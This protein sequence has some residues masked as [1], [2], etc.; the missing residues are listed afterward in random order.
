MSSV[1]EWDWTKYKN[2]T[3]DRA[4]TLS[5]ELK[6]QYHNC[7]VMMQKKK[8]LESVVK[9]TENTQLKKYFRTTPYNL[10]KRP[11]Y[12]RIID[13]IFQSENMEMTELE[14]RSCEL[15][16]DILYIYSEKKREME[17]L[18]DLINDIAA[19]RNHEEEMRESFMEDWRGCD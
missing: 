3:F 2:I 6:I 9:C 15:I 18:E 17:Y 19:R 13:E 1:Y 11:F 4:L 7:S 14:K 5:K 12:Q 8:E 16:K 10:R